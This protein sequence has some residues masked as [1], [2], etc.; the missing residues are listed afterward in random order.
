MATAP[1]SSWLIYGAYGYTGRRIAR[2]AV[3]RGLRPILAGRDERRLCSLGN[4][5]DCPIRVFALGR[6]SSRQADVGGDLSHIAVKSARCAHGKRLAERVA[7]ADGHL[8]GVRL[9]LNCAG[10]F[11]RTAPDCIAACLAARAAYLDITGEIDMIEMAAAQHARAVEAGVC[12][13]PAVGFDVVPSDCLAARLHELLRERARTKASLSETRLASAREA[14]TGEAVRLQLA[15]WSSDTLSPGTARTAWETAWAGAQARVDGRIRRVSAAR[16]LRVPF[17]DR[18]RDAMLVPWGDVASAYYTTGI[19]NIEVYAALPRPVLWLRR[20]QWLAP[21]AGLP[22]LRQTVSWVIRHAVRGPGDDAL[23]RSRAEFWGR[24]TDAQG[25]SVE[26][27]MSTIGGYALTVRTA[28]AA[29]ERVLRGD[30]PPG[31]HTP[32]RAFGVHFAEEAA[33][34]AWK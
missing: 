22:G 33:G 13:I 28:L 16:L 8:D 24:A 2:A 23:A 18:P 32:A 6:A 4:E 27:T 1:A 15:F 20:L 29:V 21:L 10:P 7:H 5:L 17:H 34:R 31:F 14:A 30:V 25:R 9:V 3:A 26:A 19:P 11:C 12:L